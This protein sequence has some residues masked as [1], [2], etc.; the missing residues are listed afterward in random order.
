MLKES[1][2][3]VLKATLFCVAFLLVYVLVFAFIIRLAQLSSSVIKP[4]NQI[5]KV[6]AVAVGAFIFVKGTKG[7]LKGAFVGL[8]ATLVSYLL[9]SVIGGSFAVSLTFLLE[10]LIAVVVGAASGAVAVNLKKS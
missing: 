4:V 1:F 10:I 6:V 7:Y 8:C 9:F 2:F 3:Q 5:F